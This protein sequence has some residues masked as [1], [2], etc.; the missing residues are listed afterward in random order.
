MPSD[1]AQAAAAGR[2]TSASSAVFG[3]EEVLDDQEVEAL[4]QVPRLR[5]W[6]ASDWTGF[7]PIT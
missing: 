3:Q 5:P 1:S 4:E 2:T 7:S 6:S